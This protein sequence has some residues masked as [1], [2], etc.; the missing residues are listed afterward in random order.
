MESWLKFSQFIEAKQ[1]E[2]GE[3]ESFQDWTGKL[4]G[5]ALRIAGLFHVVE[6]G[7]S[8]LIINQATMERALDLAEILIEHARAAFD[9]ME[10]D[11]CIDDAKHVLR[12]IRRNNQSSFKRSDCHKALHSRFKKVDRLVK[13]LS[14]LEER[15][16]ISA[17]K[18]LK[19]QKPT[20]IH[21]VNPAILGG[22]S[23]G[24]A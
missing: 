21:Y 4:P 3:F 7:D 19:T 10:A 8:T 11:P 16:I 12:W 14:I 2:G 6:F 24:L 18:S 17:L 23:H 13:A 20:L 5:A 22:G 1:G 15:N 9:L